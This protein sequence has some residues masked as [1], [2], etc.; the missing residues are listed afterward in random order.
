MDSKHS[1]ALTFAVY[2]NG[3]LVR[4]ETVTEEVIKVGSDV[5]AHLRITDA[6][7]SR[8]H[9]IIEATA[10]D[11]VTLID[12]GNDS[13][14]KVNNTPVTKCFISSGDQITIGETNIVLER[15]ES[16]AVAA[17]PVNAPF[18][19]AASNPFAGSPDPF[20]FNNPFAAKA[21]M[22]MDDVAADAPEGSYTYALL[23][24][25]PEV[26]AEEVEDA[27]VSSVEV[28]IL[29][30][31]TALHVQ[32][33][34]PPRSFY[35]G[36]EH[37]KGSPCDYFI[38]SEKLGATRAPIVLTDR[39][40]VVSIVLLPGAT[41]T[42]EIPGQAK[43]TVQE[44][45][46]QGLAQPCAE[47]SGAFQVALSGGSKATLAMGGLVFKVSSGN[48]GRAVAGG[49]RMDSQGLLYAGLSFAVHASLLAA[50]AL[51]V[52]P[53]GATEEGEISQE[54]MYLL[55]TYLD[56][57][58]EQERAAK[59][60]EP[61][62]DTR[63]TEPAGGSG[64]R[65]MG[66]EGKMGAPNSRATDG[67]FAIAGK[68]NLTPQQAKAAALNEAR[69]GFMISLLNSGVGG[70]PNAPTAP[71]GR[72][73]SLGNDPMSYRGNMWGTDIGEAYGPGGLGLTGVGEGGGGLYTGI[74]MGSIGTIGHGR[75]TGDGQGFGPGRGGSHG[76]VP[77]AHRISVPRMTSSP[78]NVSGRL[79]PEVV[80]RIVR[81]NFGRF[82]ACYE[83]GLRAN[84]SLT[85]RVAVRFVI[86]RDGGVSNVANGGSDMSDATTVACVVRAFYGLSFPQPENG[87]VA[88]TYPIMFSPGS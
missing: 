14:T 23:K 64:A 83:T 88:V 69:T 25:A 29:W 24:N 55:R 12:L 32:H 39:A 79:P 71:W 11:R 74:G 75:G 47:L 85:G 30:D 6:R 50:M 7:A 48:A 63:T 41:G 72:D 43:K 19:V 80:Q 46:A 67:R 73:V 3:T 26:A 86:G 59:A 5:K 13:G 42:I 4:R 49:F 33:L 44:V 9:A 65:A 38:P 18:V 78:P 68:D 17:V 54:Q 22:P 21:P 34:T 66:D 15:V 40:G 58:G 57:V 45:I 56:P 70:D 53:M 8:M 87:I 1:I 52:P 35:V 61:T 10:L 77:G 20:A 2:Q 51:F 60:D 28:M 62:V 81:Q 76:V 27:R 36:E 16:A 82:R 37:E 84:P 31:T